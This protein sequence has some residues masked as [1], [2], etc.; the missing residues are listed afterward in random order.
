MWLGTM[1]TFRFGIPCAVALNKPAPP[2]GGSFCIDSFPAQSFSRLDFAVVQ[3][4]LCG[5]GGGDPGD[6]AAGVAGG[7]SEVAAVWGAG[8]GLS[9]GDCFVS[10]AG[11]GVG[12]VSCGGFGGADG[13]VGVPA[14][15][16]EG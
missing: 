4:S 5:G 9:A 14:Y 2:E 10:A 1:R 8:V 3:I 6:A 15:C 12:D 7:V 16:G 11:S 13:D